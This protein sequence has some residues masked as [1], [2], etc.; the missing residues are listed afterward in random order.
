MQE[1]VNNPL[2]ELNAS[3]VRILACLMEKEL[4]TPEQ[5]PLTENAV[6][7]ACNQKTNRIPVMQLELGDVIR[8]LRDLEAADWAIAD[9]GARAERYSHRVRSRL[10]ISKAQQAILAMIL[11]RG[12]QTLAELRART[13]RMVESD[14][15]LLD[16]LTASMGGDQPIITIM[17]RQPGQ[18]EER[19]QQQVFPQQLLQSAVAR[20]E[21]ETGCAAQGEDISSINEDRLA[22]LEERV[23]KLEARIATLEGR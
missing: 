15:E 7:L 22:A 6:K 23:A 20:R 13:E 19:Y 10:K 9:R 2:Y 21:Y 1:T 17:E 5:Y 8:G 18:R 14:D 4:T 11:L 16:A 12:P 3:E